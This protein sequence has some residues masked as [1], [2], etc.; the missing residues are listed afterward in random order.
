MEELQRLAKIYYKATTTKY[1]TRVETA[2]DSF[3]RVPMIG[4]E[5]PWFKDY[6]KQA[7]ITTD[8]EVWEVAYIGS[9]GTPHLRAGMELDDRRDAAAARKAAYMSPE[10]RVLRGFSRKPPPPKKGGSKK[11]RS[12]K[13]K[14][15]KSRKN[16]KNKNKKTRR[17]R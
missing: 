2:P 12:K 16:N 1:G 9:N 13:S 7:A 3:T 8:K 15:K 14:R 5:D 11:Y 6:E 4:L 17:K 10:A